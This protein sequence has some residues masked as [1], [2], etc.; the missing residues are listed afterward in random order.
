ML[1]RIEA[2]R[3]RK[4]VLISKSV[5]LKILLNI[6]TVG[7][8]LQRVDCTFK[9]TKKLNRDLL[10]LFDKPKIPGNCRFR[11]LIYNSGTTKKPM[12]HNLY[13]PEIH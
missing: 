8:L 12:Q 1:S 13:S 2:F 4:I 7:C 5:D 11:Y 3:N 6:R 9:S 10:D